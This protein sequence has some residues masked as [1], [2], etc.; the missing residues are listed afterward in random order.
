M[1][2]GSRRPPCSTAFVRIGTLRHTVV[3]GPAEVI[4]TGSGRRNRTRASELCDFRLDQGT[5]R[6][7]GFPAAPVDAA[8]NG[9]AREHPTLPARAMPWG[10]CDGS[11]DSPSPLTDGR[12]RLS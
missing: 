4:S 11:T 12:C 9:G 3:E 2:G 7:A 5:D 1:S 6:G 8:C 10:E